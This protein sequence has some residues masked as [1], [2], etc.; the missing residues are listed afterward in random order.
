MSKFFSTFSKSNDTLKCVIERTTEECGVGAAAY[1]Q[2]YMDTSISPLKSFFACAD[3][4]EWY[5]Y[6]SDKY[7]FWNSKISLQ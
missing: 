3:N 4:R 1:V 6:Q 7:P 5:L 2:R